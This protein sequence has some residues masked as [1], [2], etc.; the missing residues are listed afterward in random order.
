[1]VWSF[2]EARRAFIAFKRAERRDGET[3]AQYDGH[4]ARWEAWRT[5]QGCGL[6]LADVTEE[7]VAAFFR[8]L[9]AEV[10]V[11]RGARRGQ[12]GYAPRTIRA[13]HRTLSTFWRWA[14]RCRRDGAYLLPPTAAYLFERGSIAIPSPARAE[15][16]A[17]TEAQFA[18]LRAAAGD[19]SDEESARDLAILWML[20]DTGARVHEL[21]ALRTEQLDFVA[22]QAAIVGKG[23]KPGCL[24]W[25]PAANAALRRYLVVRRGP[26]SGPLF[27]GVSSRNPG[28]DCSP[29]LIR[30]ML[31][32]LARRA[33]ITLPVGSPCHAFRHAFARRMRAAGLSKREVG[34]LLRDETPEVI[35]QYL[36][37]DTEARRRLYR[38]ATGQA[39]TAS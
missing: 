4:L 1:M 6:D 22:M 39:R 33:G 34:E 31:K 12:A 3:L 21:A 36:G 2:T 7:E 18:A 27:R 8:Y 37:L 19:G 15:R 24:F 13:Y 20:W 30:T 28:R 17:I 29:N 14:R 26:W 32:R 38:R 10:V 5:H 35:D 16:P 11:D 23:G 9:A 25:T